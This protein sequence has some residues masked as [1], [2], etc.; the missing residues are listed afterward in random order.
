MS[1]TEITSPAPDDDLATLMATYGSR[2]E[3][4]RVITRK[5]DMEREIEVTLRKPEMG[6]FTHS[7]ALSSPST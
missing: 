6:C 3:H 1:E 7:S 5:G 4:M 2:V